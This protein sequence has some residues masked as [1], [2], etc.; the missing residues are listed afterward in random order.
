MHLNVDDDANDVFPSDAA[1]VRLNNASAKYTALVQ[2]ML[3]VRELRFLLIKHTAL[4]PCTFVLRRLI[5]RYCIVLHRVDATLLRSSFTPFSFLNNPLG[6]G[7]E[8]TCGCNIGW[9]W[10]FFYGSEHDGVFWR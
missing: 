4:E 7:H 8:V 6:F 9:A 1:S 5:I 3:Q 2:T 10:V